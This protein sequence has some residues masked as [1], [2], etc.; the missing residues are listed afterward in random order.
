MTTLVHCTAAGMLLGAG[1]SGRV[2]VIMSWL[3][4]TQHMS[5]VYSILYSTYQLCQGYW[6]ILLLYIL[7]CTDTLHCAQKPKGKSLFI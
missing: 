7:V 6:N 4:R 3:P 2:F 1:K 5:T